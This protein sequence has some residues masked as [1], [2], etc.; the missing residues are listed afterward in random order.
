MNCRDCRERI[1]RDG[2]GPEIESHLEGCADCRE[3]Q[4]GL[5]ET[6][7]FLRET[8]EW[9]LEETHLA[10]VRARVLE[11]LESRRRWWPVWAAGLA[12]AAATLLALVW[13]VSLHQRAERVETRFVAKP[14]AHTAPVERAPGSSAAPPVLAAEKAPR[15]KPPARVRRMPRPPIAEPAEPLMVKLVTDDPDV[16][17]YWII[18]AKGD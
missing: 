2:G 5:R 11:R 17:I 13:A 7:R 14:P 1:A 4:A 18:D 10:A 12:A 8:H 3:F 6:L 16:V 15:P 9:S